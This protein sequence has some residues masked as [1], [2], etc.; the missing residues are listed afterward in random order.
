MQSFDHNKSSSTS[1]FI[2]DESRVLQKLLRYLSGIVTSTF[3]DVTGG[4]AG[5]STSPGFPGCGGLF[6]VSPTIFILYSND[7]LSK[8]L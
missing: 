6:G 1:N 5:W 8:A 2:K 4:C 7:L 3:K